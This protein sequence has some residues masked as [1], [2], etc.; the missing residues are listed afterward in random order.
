MARVLF[1][2]FMRWILD[3]DETQLT[4]SFYFF[5]AVFAATPCWMHDDAA[6]LSQ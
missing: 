4:L 6:F 3:E 1:S 2:K 5:I